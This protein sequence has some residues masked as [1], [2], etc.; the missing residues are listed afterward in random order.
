MCKIFGYPYRILIFDDHSHQKD[1][2]ANFYRSIVFLFY[3]GIGAYISRR[4]FGHDA[5]IVSLIIGAIFIILTLLHV[6][7]RSIKPEV[8]DVASIRNKIH[9]TLDFILKWVTLFFAFFYKGGESSIKT[10]MD[11]DR[12]LTKQVRQ[13]IIKQVNEIYGIDVE[14]KKEDPIGTEI[15]WL[16]YFRSIETLPIMRAYTYKWFILSGLHRNVG[17]AL[18]MA[19]IFVSLPAISEENSV[20]FSYIS[21]CLFASSMIMSVRYYFIYYNYFSKSVFRSFV[22]NHVSLQKPDETGPS[23]EKQHI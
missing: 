20:F 18:I 22:A 4:L 6:I 19:A 5:V 16:I 12:P 23:V 7:E 3:I 8:G 17:G 21:L 1:S 11:L 14:S 10:I 13:L 9:K 15:Y 2:I